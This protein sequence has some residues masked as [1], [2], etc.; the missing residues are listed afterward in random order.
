MQ[1]KRRRLGTMWLDYEHCGF[2]L[3]VPGEEILDL[4]EFV[5]QS[6]YI[7]T[8]RGEIQFARYL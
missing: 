5:G 8:D 6:S 4:S 7:A 1:R 2:T 3:L